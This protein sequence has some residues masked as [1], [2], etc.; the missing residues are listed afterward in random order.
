M[1][2]VDIET[3][4]AL[5]NPSRFTRVLAVLVGITAIVAGLLAVTESHAGRQEERS[6]LLSSRLAAAATGRIPSSSLLTSFEA[7]SQQE[8]IARQ[9]RG[10]SR[11]LSLGDGALANDEVQFALAQ[12]DITTGERLVEIASTMG[13]VPDEASGVD[14]FTRQVLSEGVAAAA[15]LV[16]D[17]NA[18]VDR[19]EAYSRRGNRAV[20]GLSILAVAAVLFGFAGT[21]R[22]SKPGVAALG[23]ATF[24]LVAS[25]ATG[26]LAFLA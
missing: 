3:A 21:V 19:A 13:A 15:Q 8:A 5:D 11:V 24:F 23:V 12:A 17:Q 4:L 25:M 7:R 14:P 20:L 6:L 16:V 2:D 9:S 1:V 10:S 22:D 26:A 18:E